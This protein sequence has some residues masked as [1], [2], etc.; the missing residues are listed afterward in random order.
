MSEKENLNDVT[1]F[2]MLKAL[3]KKWKSLLCIT[4][5]ALMVGAGIGAAMSLMTSKSYGASVEFYITSEKA[6]RYILSLVKSD[7][8]AEELLMDENGLPAEY[9]DTDGY[10]VAADI[11]KQINDLSKELEKIE[12]ELVYYPRKVSDAL[13]LSNDAQKEYEEISKHLEIMYGS[14]DAISYKDQI[15]DAERELDAAKAKKDQAKADY[16]AIYAEHEDKKEEVSKKTQ[17]I[18]DLK[19]EFYLIKKELVDVYRGDATNTEKIIKIKESVTYNY[20]DNKDIDSQAVL[21]VEIA[22]TEDKDAAKMLL[23]KLPEKM[24][25]FISDNVNQ[26]IGCEYMSALST[27]KEL[28]ICPLVSTAVKYGVIAAAIMLVLSSCVTVAVFIYKADKK[29]ND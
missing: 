10:K 17:E 18:D 20:D 28:A 12:D 8:F 14:G 19:Q 2:D 26:E 23:E 13:K 6:N 22:V 1:L 11:K 15:I 7:S 29:E 24:P 25:E 9:K 4:L 5:V 21:K 16:N 27:V 3:L